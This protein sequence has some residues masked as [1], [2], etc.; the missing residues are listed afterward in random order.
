[1]LFWQ[2]I[3]KLVCDTGVQSVDID[4]KQ[5]KVLVTGDVS[6]DDILQTVS[7]TGKKTELW[8]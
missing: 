2:L 8:Q 5:Q 1:M 4:L 6:Q 3:L 7:K